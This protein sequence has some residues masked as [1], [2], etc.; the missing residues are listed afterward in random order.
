MTGRQKLFVDGTN[1]FGYM[2]ISTQEERQKQKYQRQEAALMKFAEEAGFE[3]TLILR[4]DKSGKNFSDRKVWQSLERL[5]HEGDT[6]VFKDVSRFTREAENG[7]AK[8]ME[9]MNEKKVEL[10]FLDSPTMNTS[11]IRDLLSVAAKQNLVLKTTLEN[12][13]KL[14]LIVE[15]DR[16]EQER[17]TFIQRVKDGIAASPKPSGRKKGSVDKLTPE[18]EYAITAYLKDRRIMKKDLVKKYH[19]SYDT[20]KKYIAIVQKKIEVA[21]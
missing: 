18:L 21:Q 1:V 19:I 16:V 9:L 7:L 2:R 17:L 11:Y 15:L 14:L 6:I 5:L 12:T 8:Y 10:I 3:Y 4:E 20:L 13:V